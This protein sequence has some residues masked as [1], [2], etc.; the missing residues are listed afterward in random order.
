MSKSR[1]KER[2]LKSKAVVSICLMLAF[3]HLLAGCVCFHPTVKQGLDTRP[4]KE[5]QKVVV[6][7]EMPWPCKVFWGTI[8]ALSWFFPGDRSTPEQKRAKEAQE[9]SVWLD[10]FNRQHRE[11]GRKKQ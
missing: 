5:G 8:G 3:T 10:Q 7:E 2:F 9:Y 1:R 4:G 6:H 11:A